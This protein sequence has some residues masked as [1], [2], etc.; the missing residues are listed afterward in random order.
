MQCSI[1]VDLEGEGSHVTRACLLRSAVCPVR[2]RLYNLGL[3]A[4]SRSKSCPR[5]SAIRIASV[6]Q[7]THNSST[8]YQHVHSITSNIGFRD[9]RPRHSRGRCSTRISS[10]STQ[11]SYRCSNLCYAGGCRLLPRCRTTRERRSSKQQEL[12]AVQPIKHA[13][14]L[15]QVG[16]LTWEQPSRAA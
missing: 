13:T 3:I 16:H 12:Y 10:D 11:A 1:R 6:K 7:E 15:Q 4:H 9:R 5:L 8:R 2:E 14:I